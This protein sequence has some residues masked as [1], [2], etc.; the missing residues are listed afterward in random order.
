MT[1]QEALAKLAEIEGLTV[2][3]LLQQGTFDVVAKGI[4]MTPGCN[5]TVDVE[6]DQREGYCEK[7]GEN[8]VKSCLVLAGVI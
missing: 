7:C 8:T 3:E 1:D 6:P 2:E 4:C 5:Y